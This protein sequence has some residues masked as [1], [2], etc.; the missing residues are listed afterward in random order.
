MIVSSGATKKRSIDPGDASRC[1]TGEELRRCGRYETQVSQKFSRGKR[2]WVK[3]LREN[4]DPTVR[5]Y[6]EKGSTMQESRENWGRGSGGGA[7]LISLTG[8]RRTKR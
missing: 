8:L 5:A 4:R 6:R 3:L 7:C 1:W 2:A